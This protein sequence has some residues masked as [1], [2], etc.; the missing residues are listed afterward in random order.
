M[1][2]EE[3]YTELNPHLTELK[4]L[5]ASIDRPGGYCA[6]AKTFVPMPVLRVDG[7]DTLS[8]PVPESQIKTLIERSR[9]SPFGKGPE[10]LVDQKVRDSWEIHPSEFSLEGRGWSEAFSEIVDSAAQGIGCPRERLRAELYKLLIYEPGGFFLPHRDTEKTDGMVATLV[11]ALPVWGS[12]GEIVVRHR[13]EEVVID[14]RVDEPSEIAWAAFYADCEHEIRP[15]LDGH[16]I[17]LVYSLVLSNGSE[18]MSAPDF[19]EEIPKIARVL[20]A[21]R[22]GAGREEKAIWLLDH[23]YSEAGLSFDTLKNVDASVAAALSEA[24]RD[25]RCTLYA[26]TVKID[27]TLDAVPDQYHGYGSGAESYSAGEV[28]DYFCSLES[29]TALDR[30][31]ENFQ[32]ILFEKE[33]VLQS[34]ELEDMYPDEEEVEEWTGNAGATVERTYRVAALV[35]WPEEN[36]FDI[37]A[38]NSIP[39]AAGYVETLLERDDPRAPGYASRLRRIWEGEAPWRAKHAIGTALRIFSRLGDISSVKLLLRAAVSDYDDVENDDIASALLLLGA[40]FAE[41]FLPIMIRENL[42]ERPEDILRLASRLCEEPG[43]DPRWREALVR[44]VCGSILLGLPDCLAYEKEQFYSWRRRKESLSPEAVRDLLASFL[45]LGLLKEAE[46]AVNLLL[47]SPERADPARAIP[48]ALEGLLRFGRSESLKTLWK[49]STEFLLGRSSEPPEFPKDWKITSVEGCGCEDCADLRRFCE[50][51]VAE[52]YRFKV[53]SERRYHLESVINDCDL[54]ID[55]RT[56]KK[57]RPYT[58]VCR[59]NRSGHEKN[60]KRYEKDLVE[61]K[62]LAAMSPASEPKNLKRLNEVL[63]RRG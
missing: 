33:E 63:A 5:L 28:I 10:T 3:D 7:M 56:E 23:D 18:R 4:G 16:R 54:E 36:T 50:D 29:L 37:I 8:F 9:R 39:E 15:V 34:E 40:E 20:A 22:K 24:A 27:E 6:F 31:R 53:N 52:E 30:T 26:A 32:R 47:D 35:L 61:M 51:T 21:W 46:Q 58:L 11:V 38:S 44:G 1:R 25:A 59:K 17:V 60:L 45:A 49:R 13:G 41:D 48:P 57:G 14:M 62:R 12:G 42:V 19:D 43:E 55:F 2:D